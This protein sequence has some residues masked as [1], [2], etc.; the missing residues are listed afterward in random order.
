M[1]LV[2]VLVCIGAVTSLLYV[3]LSA[4]L[5]HRA[6]RDGPW[7]ADTLARPDG[8]FEVVVA[9]N[10]QHP[11]TVRELPADLDPIELASELRLAGDEAQLLAEELNRAR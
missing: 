8:T 11:R 3:V 7:R 1:R 6:R 9:R 4:W 5:V 2:L 10:G